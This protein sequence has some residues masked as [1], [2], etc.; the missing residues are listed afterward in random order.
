MPTSQALNRSVTQVG[1]E[2]VNASWS[3]DTLLVRTLVLKWQ[4]V[5]DSHSNHN[6]LS[7]KPS[8]DNICMSCIDFI[9]RNVDY[10]R[11][12]LEICEGER[13]LFN[14]MLHIEMLDTIG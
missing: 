6:V 14:C 4:E 8:H 5:F 13:A 3:I 1:V 9:E 7:L 11:V 12:T 2:I 10:A